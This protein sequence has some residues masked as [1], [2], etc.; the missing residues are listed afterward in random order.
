[1]VIEMIYTYKEAQNKYGSNYQIEQG[2]KHGELFKLERGLYSN[3]PSISPYAAAAR[4]YPHAIITMDSAYYIHGLTDVIPQTTHLATRRNATRIADARIKQFFTEDWLF[5]PG[6][7]YMEYDNSTIRIYSKERMLVE[8]MRNSKS[9]P[10]DYYKE[11]IL[12]Y[13]KQVDDLDI[14]SI[15]EYIGLFDR[16]EYMF[17]ILQREVL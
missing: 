2:I 3:K 16:N 4:R 6:S 12:S 15:E 17:N 14:Q 8:L 13:R 11:I 9:L 7:V 10:L 5:E 1:M